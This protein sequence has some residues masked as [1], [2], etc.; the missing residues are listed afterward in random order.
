MLCPFLLDPVYRP[1]YFA[2][3]A[4]IFKQH[5][6]KTTDKKATDNCLG[7]SSPSPERQKHELGKLETSFQPRRIP[8]QA[9]LADP[10]SVWNQ[11]EELQ[12]SPKIY[13]MFGV[14]LSHSMRYLL[15]V[16]VELIDIHIVDMYDSLLKMELSLIENTLYTIH[17]IDTFMLKDSY[18]KKITS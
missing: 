6:H 1:E 8:I 2:M 5:R 13:N 7:E 18:M 17:H 10:W 15:D 14:E 11:Y 3:I 16:C 9:L 12:P 4:D